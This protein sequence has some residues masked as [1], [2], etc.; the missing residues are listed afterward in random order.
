MLHAGQAC[1]PL[2]THKHSQPASFSPLPGPPPELTHLVG[3]GLLYGP[4]LGGGR[5]RHCQLLPQ[6]HQLRLMLGLPG[7]QLRPKGAGARLG[8]RQLLRV[9]CHEAGRMQGKGEWG[10]TGE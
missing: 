8:S 6:P 1:S 10:V 7:L 3:Q 9:T 2:S 5:V 4:R